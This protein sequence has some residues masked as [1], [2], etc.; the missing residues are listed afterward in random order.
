MKLL[1]ELLYYDKLDSGAFHLND[2]LLSPL[3]LVEESFEMFRPQVRRL[4]LAAPP[5][6]TW[7]LPGLSLTKSFEM[8]R[9]QVRRLPLAAPSLSPGLS[10][11]SPSLTGTQELRDV[12]AAISAHQGSPGFGGLSLAAPDPSSWPLCDP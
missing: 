12:P 9:P 2:S 11:A 4:P 1:D 8:F 3:E 5:L 10:L 7:P 6:S